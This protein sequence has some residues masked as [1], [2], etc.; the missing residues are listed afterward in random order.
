MP[1]RSSIAEVS[2]SVKHNAL[3][4][5]LPTRAMTHSGWYCD[6]RG[7]R[8]ET[9]RLSEVTWI[10]SCRTTSSAAAAVVSNKEPRET[11]IA[12]AVGCSGWFGP[13]AFPTLYGPE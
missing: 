10:S 1:V 4:L 11:D 3:A 8:S 13:A 2:H 9:N 6:D 12:A 7:N 5:P